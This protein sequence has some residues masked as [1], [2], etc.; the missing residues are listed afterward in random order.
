MKLKKNKQYNV[1]VLPNYI[2]SLQNTETVKHMHVTYKG[3]FSNLQF[4]DRK[5][6]IIE[7]PQT[8]ING[9]VFITD[10]QID[11]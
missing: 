7:V 3:K 5:G 10:M 9:T 4:E 1:I 2:E 8:Q 6:K 11:F